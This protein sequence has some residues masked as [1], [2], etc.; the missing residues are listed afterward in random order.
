MKFFMLI[1]LF[2]ISIMPSQIAA[3][4]SEDHIL[5]ISTA[6]NSPVRL[7]KKRL[8]EIIPKNTNIIYTFVPRGL[9][10]SIDENH[11]FTGESTAINC[12]ARIILDSIATILNEI[13]NDCTIE[14]H[15]EGHDDN[16]G[17]Y[18]TNW[19]ISMARA[20]NI[21]DYLIY[22]GKI[23][24]ERVFPLGFGELM[25]FKENVSNK[26]TGFDKRIDFVIFDYEYE[27]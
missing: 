3:Q 19:E 22:C 10:I 18:K 2:F 11:F 13:E 15:T 17:T 25:P 14:C 1:I 6:I 4:E 26:I 7:I 9:I 27:R 12:S 16:I 23:P 8:E 5:C 21:A 24:T 20:N